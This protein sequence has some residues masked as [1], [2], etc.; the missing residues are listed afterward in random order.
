MVE[1]SF[2]GLS[3]IIG[4]VGEMHSLISYQ[5][6]EVSHRHVAHEPWCG[7]KTGISNVRSESMPSDSVQ[8]C[9]PFAKL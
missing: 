9:W 5:E 4:A 7:I 6:G 8:Q 1:L 3:P 2:Y